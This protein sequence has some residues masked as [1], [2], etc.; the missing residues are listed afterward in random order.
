MKTIE[1]LRLLR[2]AVDP[3]T[4]ILWAIA[5]DG[6]RE[7]VLRPGGVHPDYRNLVNAAPI[8]FRVA[9][10]TQAGLTALVEW[11]ECIDANA[12]V[13]GI[14]TMQGSLNVAVRCAVE[15]IEKVA[16]S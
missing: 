8:L 3:S 6:S 9:D 4:G 7:E 2:G 5:P 10:E 13:N 16:G 12:A 1:Q 11:L 14:L 15:G